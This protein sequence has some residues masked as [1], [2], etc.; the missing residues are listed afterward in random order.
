MQL[1]SL[2]AGQIHQGFSLLYLSGSPIYLP[3][4]S[5]LPHPYRTGKEEE[6]KEKPEEEEVRASLSAPL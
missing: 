4:G 2:A 6:E 1:A 3:A 5:G